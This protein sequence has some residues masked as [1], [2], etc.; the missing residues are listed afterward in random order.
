M[1]NDH[2]EIT[3][4]NLK[5]FR[6][7]ADLTQA[8]LGVLLGLEKYH[9]SHIE[10]GRRQIS[11]AEMKLLRLY[12]FGELPELTRNGEELTRGLLNFTDL[13][14]KAICILALKA[15]TTPS[16]WIQR[17]IVSYLDYADLGKRARLT[18][19]GLDRQAAMEKDNRLC[20]AEMDGEQA[21]PRVMKPVKYPKPE[22]KK[23]LKPLDDPEAE[24]GNGTEGN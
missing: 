12:F 18:I 2:P 19:D 20:V 16:V 15:G 13:E 3:S 23:K 24:P 21:T 6:I 22:R 9:I 14:W 7:Q 1:A 4:E 8:D 17:Q 11:P 10:A 5:K